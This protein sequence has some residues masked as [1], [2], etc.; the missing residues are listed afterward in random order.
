[1]PAFTDDAGTTFPTIDRTAGAIITSNGVKA[2]ILIHPDS[3]VKGSVADLKGTAVPSGRVP[4]YVTVTYTNAGTTTLQFPSLGT[5]LHAADSA[6]LQALPFP[7]GGT[8]AQCTSTDAPENF[9]PGASFTDCQIFLVHKGTTLAE[10]TY[11]PTDRASEITWK[12]AV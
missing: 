7:V 11:R 3:V 10:L 12:I 6:G 1:V 4:V 5:D 2:Q 9:R 8:V